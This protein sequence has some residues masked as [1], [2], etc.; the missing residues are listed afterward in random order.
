[1]QTPST[2][3]DE[4]LHHLQFARAYS[5]HT[6]TSYRVDLDQFVKFLEARNEV[7]QFPERITKLSVRAYLAH[8][9]ENAYSKAS[10]ARKLASMRSMFKYLIKSKVTEN[11][12]LIGV[13]TPKQERRLPVFLNE[14]DV[15]K[16]LAAVKGDAVWDKRDQAIM[17]VLYSTG[18][19]VSELVGLNREDIDLASQVVRAR[20]KGK[21]ERMVPMGGPAGAILGAYLRLLGEQPKFADF[22]QRSIFLNKFGARL[23]TRSVARIIDKYIKVAGLTSKV[24]PHTLRHSFATHML[25]RGANLRSVQELLG[26]E[27]LST[28]QIY[29]HLTAERMKAVYD[30]SH[31]RA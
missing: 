6:L 30:A 12:P 21:K 28:T 4:F 7:D 15:S 31:P 13:H 19:R 16:L 20:G 10:V 8:L 5:G 11:N 24:S 27:S 23:T 18:L 25:D 9:N 26:H 22:D 14:D 2:A 29:T 1:M 17:E 3:I